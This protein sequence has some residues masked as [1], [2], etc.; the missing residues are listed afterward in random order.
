MITYHKHDF[1]Y[2]NII[3]PNT[4]LLHFFFHNFFGVYIIVQ[5]II[6][7]SKYIVVVSIYLLHGNILADLPFFWKTIRIINT[8]M[9][10]FGRRLF[11]QFTFIL[12]FVYHIYVVKLNIRFDKIMILIRAWQF[13]FSRKCTEMKRIEIG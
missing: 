3:I 7:T 6:G 5:Y 12:S 2:R 4:L 13:F 9:Y 10:S 1:F 11:G 8:G